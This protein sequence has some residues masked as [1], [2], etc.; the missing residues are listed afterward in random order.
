MS[1]LRS[2]LSA[3]D[4][5]ET[6]DAVA[7]HASASATIAGAVSGLGAAEVARR[8]LS[9]SQIRDL[10]RAE[11]DERLTAARQVTAGGHVERAAALLAEAAV[12]ADML[13]DV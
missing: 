13:G 7:V 10:L 3:I 11:V 5:A 6:P 4:N 9:D 8:E 1:A 12:L 2:A